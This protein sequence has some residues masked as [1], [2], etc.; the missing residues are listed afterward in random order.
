MFLYKLDSLFSLRCL[1]LLSF[2]FL[3]LILPFQ[4]KYQFFFH[5]EKEN[6]KENCNWACFPIIAYETLITYTIPSFSR[7]Q[8]KSPF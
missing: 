6:K 2:S 1:G 5:R 3:M 4:F 8:T 7:F